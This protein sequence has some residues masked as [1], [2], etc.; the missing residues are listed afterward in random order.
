M[1]L[2]TVIKASATASTA[3]KATAAVAVC[4]TV[5]VT[6]SVVESSSGHY[7]DAVEGSSME[8]TITAVEDSKENADI[9]LEGS[10]ATD[11]SESETME[12]LV[13][14]L[15]H[16]ETD[17]SLVTDVQKNDSSVKAAVVGE[18]TVVEI[19]NGSAANGSSAILSANNGSVNTDS[20]NQATVASDTDS[21]SGKTTVGAY[22]S[23]TGSSSVYTTDGNKTTD[24]SE[25]DNN[26]ANIVVY[27]A[28]SNEAVAANGTDDNKTYHHTSSIYDDDDATLLRVEYLDEN[29][30]IVEYS[31]VTD[32][33]KDTNSYTET[34]YAYDW[35]EEKEYVM[36]TDTY[37]DGELVSSEKP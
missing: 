13:E 20:H 30:K 16:E 21:S 17:G 18:T 14:L 27:A 12:V 9:S 2:L 23:N 36:R 11:D 19:G 32:Y 5:L 22:D 28:D 26:S 15:S 35:D 33:D 7:A 3:I 31:A 1:H 37:V 34:V 8:K 10:L 6:A 25:T 24:V 4:T 29:G